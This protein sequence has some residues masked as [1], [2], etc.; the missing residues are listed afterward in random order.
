MVHNGSP[1][2]KMDDLGIPPFQDTSISPQSTLVIG[3]KK[4][5]SLPMGPHPALVE[6]SHLFYSRGSGSIFSCRACATGEGLMVTPAQMEGGMPWEFVTWRTV[7]WRRDV[8]YG[9]PIG[10]ECNS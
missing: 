1:Q 10:M 4:P 8:S 3:L 9:S 2:S 5:T 6:F 7:G